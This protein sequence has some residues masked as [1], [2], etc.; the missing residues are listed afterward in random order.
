MLYSAAHDLNYRRILI[1][2]GPLKWSHCELILQAKA[3]QTTYFN[4]PRHKRQGSPSL[5]QMEPR[6]NYLPAGLPFI[7]YAGS[8]LMINLLPPNTA[9]AISSFF[10]RISSDFSL[11]STNQAT[12]IFFGWGPIFPA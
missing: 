8:R 4:G 6:I 9:I 5:K 11:F 1:Q 2:L 7:E 12:K 10:P 3:L